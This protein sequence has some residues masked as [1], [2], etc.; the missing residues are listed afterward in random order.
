MS[1]DRAVP[2]TRDPDGYTIENMVEDL[3]GVRRDLNLGKINLLGHS[4]VGLWC[5]P[6]R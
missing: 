1:A 2:E 5:K 6:T 4:M 3:E